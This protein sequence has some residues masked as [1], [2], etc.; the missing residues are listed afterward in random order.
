MLLGS[1][2]LLVVGSSLVVMSGLRIVRQAASAGLPVGAV[3]MGRTRGDEFLSFK[4][5]VDCV[6]VFDSVIKQISP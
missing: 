6:E 2:A 3:N 1:D 5:S 4:V